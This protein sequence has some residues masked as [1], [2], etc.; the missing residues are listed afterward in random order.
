MA[1]PLFGTSATQAAMLYSAL[2]PEK[3]LAYYRSLRD[4]GLQIFEGNSVVRD[5]V[6]SGALA[7]GVVDNDDAQV[8]IERGADVS[9]VVP[10]VDRAETLYIPNT[11][12]LIAG[13]PHVNKG[14][15]LVEFLV[16]AQVEDHLAKAGFFCASVRRPPAG[17]R[18]DWH[19]V[20]DSLGRAKSDCKELF[21]K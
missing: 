16:S 20:G 1:N 3:A 19:S 2:G 14:R 4:A 18:V 15:E 10:D 21:L 13:A 17:L 6:V 11:V 12:A 7:V 5:A 8:A 9:I